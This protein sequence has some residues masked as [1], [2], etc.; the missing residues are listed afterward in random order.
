M[1]FVGLHATVVHRARTYALV[2]LGAGILA[3]FFD[4]A[5]NAFFVT[6]ALLA[7]NGVPL[8]DPALPWIYIAAN[9]KWMTAFATL[10][11]FGLVWPRDD[12]LGWL[13]T[14]LMLLFPIIGVLGVASPSLVDVRG[15]FFLLGMPLFA[16]HFWREARRG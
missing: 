3:A 8:T 4:V 9:L 16:W 11:A 1:L 6:Y 12:W 13:L 10:Y 15:L 5:E 7:L 14:V 2:G